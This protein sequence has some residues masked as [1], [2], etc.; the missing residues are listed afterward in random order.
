MR[1]L[2]VGAG[3]TGGYYGGRLAAVG[4]DVTFLVRPRRQR[5]LAERGLVIESPLGDVA[6]RDPTTVLASALASP[7]D[8]I[9]L[10]ANAP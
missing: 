7:F 1:I 3:A 9:L 5:Q 4:C 6:V 8:A 2:T 10:S